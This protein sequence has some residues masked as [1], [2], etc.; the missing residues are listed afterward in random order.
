[1]RVPTI[2]AAV[3]EQ[4]YEA[5]R[6][7]PVKT[8]GATLAFSTPPTMQTAGQRAPNTGVPAAAS[9]YSPQNDP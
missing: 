7:P 5:E 8:H 2:T 1:M 9:A 4:H 6:R 3:V